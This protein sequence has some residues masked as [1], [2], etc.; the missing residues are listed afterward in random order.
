MKLPLLAARFTFAQAPAWAESVHFAAALPSR[1]LA[2][3][4][5]LDGITRRVRALLPGSWKD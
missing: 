1:R 3:E 5:V 4:Q 2:A